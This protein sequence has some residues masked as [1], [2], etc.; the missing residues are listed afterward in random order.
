MTAGLET[1]TWTTATHLDPPTDVQLSDKDAW[2]VASDCKKQ[3]TLQSCTSQRS[4]ECV[5][6]CV[7]VCVN[8]LLVML[9][10]AVSAGLTADVVDVTAG[11]DDT[12]LLAAAAAAGL[13]G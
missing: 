5:C 11:L 8:N 4:S 6:V 9:A 2:N 10:C 13:P 12:L 3:K 1:P 7:C